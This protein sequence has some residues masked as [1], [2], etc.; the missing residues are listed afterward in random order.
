MPNTPRAANCAHC[1]REW[2]TRSKTAR[3]CSPQCR[4]RLREIEHGPT[5]GAPLRD[6]PEDVVA[7]VRELYES[8]M[9]RT[10]VQEAIGP[11]IKVENVMRRYGI[12]SRSAAPR[13]GVWVEEKNPAWKGKEAGYQALHLRVESRR[14]KPSYCSRCGSSDP[15]AR[16]EWANMTGEYA[17]V[18]DYERM[19]VS[20]HR[21][22]DS[23]RRERTGARTS[24][25][26]R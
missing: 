9:T 6:Y 24:P 26:R 14:G 20:C 8:G 19:C 4:A 21:R 22:Y 2:S 23:A 12:N 10:E 25:V 17:D 7:R 13:I 1:G 15:A 11:G 16:Y 3:T 18:N 5:K